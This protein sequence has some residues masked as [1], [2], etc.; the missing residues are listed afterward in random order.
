MKLPKYIACIASYYDVDPSVEV[1]KSIV[2]TRA[3]DDSV[4][5]RRCSLVEF[6]RNKVDLSLTIQS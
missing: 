2:I 6:L 4:V 1:L 3:N 5:V